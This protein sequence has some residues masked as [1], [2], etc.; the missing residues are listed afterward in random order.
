MEVES[1]PEEVKE[2]IKPRSTSAAPK[3]I[4]GLGDISQ[5]FKFSDQ[6]PGDLNHFRKLVSALGGEYNV[7]PSKFAAVPNKAQK[8]FVPNVSGIQKSKFIPLFS[9]L[10]ANTLKL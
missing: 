7:A 8:K 3:R 9:L 1:E 2:V 6:A 4:T 5:K 10:Y